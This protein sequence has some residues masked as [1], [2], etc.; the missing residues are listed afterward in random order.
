MGN[1]WM[2]VVILAWPLTVGQIVWAIVFG[3]SPMLTPVMFVVGF[4]V[5]LTCHPP[6]VRLLDRNPNW[7]RKP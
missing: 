3:A 6:L 1:W 5:G 4:V 2:A 7:W